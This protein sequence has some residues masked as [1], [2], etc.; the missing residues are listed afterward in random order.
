MGALESINLSIPLDG[1]Q[2]QLIKNKPAPMEKYTFKKQVPEKFWEIL[3]AQKSLPANSE[4][5]KRFTSKLFD[6]KHIY[7]CNRLKKDFH[8]HADPVKCKCTNCNEP[9]D[10]YHECQPIL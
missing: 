9:M 8:K 10:W 6:L 1:H 4:L 2:L 7:Q 3:H 5:R